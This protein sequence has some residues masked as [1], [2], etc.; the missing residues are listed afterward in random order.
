MIT[1]LRPSLFSHPA[2]LLAHRLAPQ[3]RDAPEE[4]APSGWHESSRELR[5]GLI[6]VEDAPADELPQ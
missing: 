6:V 4:P 1:S 5:D 2:A 3:R